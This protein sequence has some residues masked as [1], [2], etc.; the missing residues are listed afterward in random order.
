MDISWNTSCSERGTFYTFLS[1]LQV[2][3]PVLIIPDIHFR[4][5]SSNIKAVK[6]AITL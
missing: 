6:M 1:L 4:Q 2:F 3:F 5:A